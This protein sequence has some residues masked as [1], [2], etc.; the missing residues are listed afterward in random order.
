MA[1]Q[2]AFASGRENRAA[3]V[4]LAKETCD[5]GTTFVG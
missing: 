1:A 5:D 4:R 3:E 2:L